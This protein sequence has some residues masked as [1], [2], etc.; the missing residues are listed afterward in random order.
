MDDREY[1]AV[2][3]VKPCLE[4]LSRGEVTDTLSRQLEIQVLARRNAWACWA[5]EVKLPPDERRVDYVDFCP[6]PSISCCSVGAVERGRFTFYEVKS[7]MSD[8]KSGHGTNWCGDANW[9]VC[10]IEMVEEMRNKQEWPEGA[11]SVGILA[12]GQRRNGSRG[13]VKLSE[14]SAE[15]HGY[16]YRKHSA[17]ELLYAMTRAGIRRG[18]SE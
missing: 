15:R 11:G 9:L 8:L 16:G 12:F 10:P 2:Y 3:G 18:R 5:S 13:F 17:A 7:C 14:K 4:G 6:H 1:L